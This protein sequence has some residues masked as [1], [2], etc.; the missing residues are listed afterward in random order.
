MAQKESEQGEW[1]FDS[2]CTEYITHLS[3]ALTNNKDT[4]F[5][6]LVIIP[7][8]DSIPV[9]GKG[10]CILPGGKKINGVLYIQDFKCNLLS[11][12]RLCNDL[13]CFIS[14]F[15]NFCVMLGLR[16][17]NL[18]GIG[19]YKGG[20]YKMN[21]TRERRAMATTIDT[22]HKRLG[23]ASKGKLA[24]VDFI[25][26]SIN[27]LDSLCDPYARAKH[28][29]LPFLLVLLKQKLLLN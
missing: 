19:R 6:N 26:T 3:N 17:R 4:P 21:M 20:L 10:E 18:I 8:G 14:F 15:L 7:N 23:H 16:K 9:K 2:G 5:E 13:Q 27:N 12:N 22:W 24:R 1:I 28:T 29:R 25:R 11:V